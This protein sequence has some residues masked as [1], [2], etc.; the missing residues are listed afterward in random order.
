MIV[1]KAD[2]QFALRAARAAGFDHTDYIVVWV[3]YP[4]QKE[5]LGFAPT[6][7]EC[8]FVEGVPHRASADVW[9]VNSET[10]RLRKESK[11]CRPRDGSTWECCS[12]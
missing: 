2:R 9:C 1:A 4:G 5:E 6:T 11:K 8:S 7:V 10:G 12:T 3:Q